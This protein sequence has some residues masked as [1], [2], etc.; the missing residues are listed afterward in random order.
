MDFNAQQMREDALLKEGRYK[1]T[2]LDAREKRSSSNNDMINLKLS[3]EVNG[4]R[5]VFY[6][7]LIFTPKMFWKIEHFCK[8]TGM[9]QKID[10]GHLIPNDCFGKEGYV[11]IVQKPDNQTG[12][13]INQVKDYIK[14]QEAEAAEMFDD[15]VKL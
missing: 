15:D 1:F 2:V 9:P 8:T 5:V 11:D 4:R 12:E 13:L 14:P 3:L 10:E 6:D 7:S